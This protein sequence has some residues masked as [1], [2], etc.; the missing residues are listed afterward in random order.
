MGAKTQKTT[1]TSGPSNPAL[2]SLL[3]KLSNGIGGA[4]KPGGT[5]YTAPGATTQSGWAQALG[6]AG[7]GDFSGGLA[8]ALKSYGNRATGAELGMND[9][10]YA[11]QRATLTDDVLKSVNGQFSSMGQLGSD[12]SRV[13][14]ARGLT[15]ALGGLDLTQR[16][17][18]YGR[19]A[20]AANM[21]GN[22]FQS[23]LLPSSITGAVGAAQDADAAAKANGGI[24]YLS[25]F[26]QLLGAAS[27]AS[28][29]T[30]TTT[31]PSTPLWQSLLGLGVSAL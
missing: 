23:S 3:T 21:L 11:R 9:P 19:Q 20:E 1:T 15:D 18:S 24:D 8:G 16:N 4:Y 5:T 14:A 13:A 6:A 28:P 26:T 30:T 2:N 10:L 31:S 12:Q 22:L 27:G 7:N 29:Q 25:K 17:E